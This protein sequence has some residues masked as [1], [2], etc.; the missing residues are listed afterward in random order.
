MG[1]DKA[2][3]RR[4]GQKTVRGLRSALRGRGEIATVLQEAER[5]TAKTTPAKWILNK[6]HYRGIIRPYLPEKK[7]EEEALEVMKEE[8]REDQSYR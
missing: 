1:Q 7:I 4:S 6:R 5:S 8:G 2:M 3:H